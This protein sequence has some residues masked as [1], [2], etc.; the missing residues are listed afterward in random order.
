[1]LQSATHQ[2]A[3]TPILPTSQGKVGPSGGLV[4]APATWYLPVETTRLAATHG[5]SI[6]ETVALMV[7]QIVQIGS[8]QGKFPVRFSSWREGPFLC[9]FIVKSEA[10]DSVSP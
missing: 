6:A 3:P 7:S 5:P 2:P 8:S 9:H 10:L 4:Q 1:M